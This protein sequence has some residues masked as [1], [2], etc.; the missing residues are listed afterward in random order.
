MSTDIV[1]RDN[2]HRVPTSDRFDIVFWQR[3]WRLIRP[4][5]QSDKRRWALTLIIVMTVLNLSTV[6]MQAIFSYV[7]RDIMNTLQVKDAA[8]FY[9][10]MILFGTW[11]VLFVPIAAFYP[12]ITGLLQIDWRNWLTESFVERMFK[13]NALYHIMRDHEVDNPDQRISQDVN[14]FTDGALTYSMTVLQAIVTAITF[15]GILWAIS[16]WL[17]VCLI[18]YAIAGTWLAVV[19]GRRLVVINFNQQRFEADYR[20]ALVHAR[21]NAEAIALYQGARDEANQ[22]RSR[23]ANVVDNFKLLILWQRHLMF[24]TSA[25]DNVAGLVPYFVLA[26][27]YFSGRFELGEFTQAAYAFS[28]LQGSLSLI[29]DQ[30]QALTDYASVVNRLAAFE[31]YCAA[32]G[33]EKS[34]EARQIEVM[35]DES[36]VALQDVTLATP[37]RSRVLQHDLSLV[38]AEGDAVLLTGPSGIGKTSLMRAIAGLWKSGGGRILRPPIEQIM[39]LPQKPYFILGSMRQQMQYP[40]AENVSDEKLLEVLRQVD[41]ANLPEQF[42][43][44]DVEHKWA[45]V[46]S[47]GEQQRLAFARLLINCPRFAIL[48]EATSALDLASEELLYK[49]LTRTPTTIISIGHRASLRAFHKR[50]IEL[51]KSLDSGIVDGNRIVQ[52]VN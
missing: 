12:Y 41:L 30:F 36:K 2:F 3:L 48:D 42:G 10:L 44:L 31:E 4:Y 18:G 21:D 29:V 9:H 34:G 13:H 1:T 16:H 51:S 8:R 47:G 6:G 28:V 5:W 52:P 35:Q 14:S 24:F 49:R 37:D 50:T 23:F 32:A 17:A 26:G 20:F 22:L 25:Y 45:E 40:R 15:F 7:S 33:N 19:I 43:G 39:F 11:I 27:A 38:I 46:L